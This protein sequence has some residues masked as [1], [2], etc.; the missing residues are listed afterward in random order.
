[1]TAICLSADASQ[2]LRY[3]SELTKFGV[4]PVHTILHMVKVAVEDFSFHNITN[5][6]I[7]LEHCGRYLLRTDATR[8]R[9]A[10]FVC[11]RCPVS[12]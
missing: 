4:V 10:Q 2:S 5:A 6:C 9:M 1:M 12:G 3:V 11:R 7:L 8:D